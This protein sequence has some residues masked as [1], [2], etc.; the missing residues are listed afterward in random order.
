MTPT[1]STLP[2]FH[3]PTHTVF[4]STINPLEKLLAPKNVA[5]VGATE[6]PGSVG[7]T[8]VWN[9]LSSPFGGTIYPVNPKRD[10]VLGIKAYPSLAAIPDTIDLVVIVT[11]AASIPALMQEAADKGIPSAI[12]ISV[13]FKEVG[14]EG[15]AREHDILAIA[16][17]NGMRIIGPNCLGVMNT[18]SGL[19]ATFAS[20]MARKGNVGFLS[21][22]GALC[23]AV[24]DWSLT[25]N[26]GFSVFASLGSMVDVDWGDLIY[27]LGDDPNTQSIVIYMETIGNA[28]SFLSAAREVALEKPIIVIKPGR[29]ECAAKAAA[30]HTGSLVGSDAVLDAAFRR[31]GVLRVD[32]IEELFAMADVLDKQP[33]P[34]GPKL[35]IITNAGGPGVIATDALLMNGGELADV[36]TATLDKLNTFLPSAWSHGNPIDI[37]GDAD[38]ERYAETLTVVNADD[39]SDGTLVIL[40]PQAM[41]DQLETARTLVKRFKQGEKPVLASWMGG[42]DVSVGRDILNQAGIPTFDYPD[43]A[44]KAFSMMWRYQKNLESLYETPGYRD[45]DTLALVDTVGLSAKLST[46]AATGLTTLTEAESKELLRAYDIP[47]T[48]IQQANTA[49]EAVVVAQGMGY[50]VVVKLHS[51]TITHKSDL[52]GVKLNISSDDGVSTAFSDIQMSLAHHGCADG[53]EGVTVQPMV[54]L[55][56]TELIIGSSYDPQFG[57]VVAFGAGGTLVELFEDVAFGLPPLNSTLVR[58]LIERTKIA[59]ALK[60]YR[61]KG[62]INMAELE[63]LLVRFSYLVI[64]HPQ[65][66]EVEINP[67]LASETGLMALDARVILHSATDS[68]SKTLQP[69]VIR[70]YPY[71]YISNITLANGEGI[72]LRPIRANDEEAI[73]EFHS[74]LTEA[75]VF[76]SYNQAMPLTERTAHHRLAR[77]CFND[78]HRELTLVSVDEAH[79]IVGVGRLSRQRVNH[80][81][82]LFRLIIQDDHQGKG[83]G[84][85]LLS[86]MI[87][88]ARLEGLTSLMGEVLASNTAMLK[89]TQSTGFSLMATDDV[90]QTIRLLL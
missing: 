45:Q 50:P 74:R 42:N 72:T 48:P 47:V 27:Y 61:G 85:Q 6:K 90:I 36:S 18:T 80:Q 11:P 49:D 76:Q 56:G 28:Q 71:Q 8:I 62:P 58:R 34:Q 65:I 4:H 43:S 78:Y 14:P 12:I 32:T 33:L 59:K 3:A 89:L 9:L 38:P 57:P 52:G 79:N 51:T 66:K 1:A 10:N 68:Q 25:N 55:K 41:T 17:E 60:G 24:L 35:N 37:L 16:K 13:G 87:E 20:G 70:A 63:A 23:T 64:N 83:L 22:S 84:R 77:I 31:C 54:S 86:R 15:L 5:V 39:H 46:I 81:T 29:T 69:N 67:L 44:A 21:Q 88:I 82:G 2:A 40:T 53:F 7:R 26:V 73:R 19:N 30:S 75:S